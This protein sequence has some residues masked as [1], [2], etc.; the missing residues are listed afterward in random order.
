MDKISKLRMSVDVVPTVHSRVY[1]LVFVP[2]NATKSWLFLF[3][4]ET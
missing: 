4:V 2:A 3:N 1:A